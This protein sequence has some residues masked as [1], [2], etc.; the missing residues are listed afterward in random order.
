MEGMEGR[1]IKLEVYHHILCS[2]R[3]TDRQT[4][5]QIGKGW[6]QFY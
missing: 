3:Q 4:D 1:T 2:H 6:W 5:R